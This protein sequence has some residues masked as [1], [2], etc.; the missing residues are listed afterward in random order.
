MTLTKQQLMS[1]QASQGTAML[2]F[3]EVEFDDPPVRLGRGG[4]GEVGRGGLGG[5]VKNR[6]KE[7]RD[8]L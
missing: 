5:G 2:D 6:G 7:E 8:S 4:F 1:L 3:L